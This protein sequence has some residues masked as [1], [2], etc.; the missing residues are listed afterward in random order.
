M[1]IFDQSQQV[2][3]DLRDARVKLIY[4][5]GDEENI[6]VSYHGNSHYAGC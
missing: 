3:G 1:V 2:I 5:D 4:G 6:I